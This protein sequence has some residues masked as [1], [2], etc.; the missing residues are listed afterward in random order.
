[1]QELEP[2]K[3]QPNPQE[4]LTLGTDEYYR[5]YYSD[6]TQAKAYFGF[7]CE[8]YDDQL[9]IP[10]IQFVHVVDNNSTEYEQLRALG[11]ECLY[12][13]GAG[14]PPRLLQ[15]FIESGEA[16]KALARVIDPEIAEQEGW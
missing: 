16:Y 9:L 12:D 3:A 8:V 2:G 10:R 14:E 1:M 4:L 15:N 13:D 11:Y 7:E 5:R 6:S